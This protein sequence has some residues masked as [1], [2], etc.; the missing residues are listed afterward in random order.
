MVKNKSKGYLQRE[1]QTVLKEHLA[2]EVCLCK[3]KKRK[4]KVLLS[5]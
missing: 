2:V 4:K 1:H 3:K 5:W